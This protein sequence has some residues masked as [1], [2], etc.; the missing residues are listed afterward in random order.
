MN[1]LNPNDLV[2]LELGRAKIE[3]ILLKSQIEE[4]RRSLKAASSPAEEGSAAAANDGQ[5]QGKARAS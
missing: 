5:D 4:M 2:A 1:T 3:I